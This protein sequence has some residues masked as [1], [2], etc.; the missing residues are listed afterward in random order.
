MRR[1]NPEG[2]ARLQRYRRRGLQRGIRRTPEMV[3]GLV[4]Y[5]YPLGTGLM[6]GA[7]FGRIAGRE[8]AKE[9][10]GGKGK[11][12]TVKKAAPKKAAAKKA[13]AKKAVVKKVVKK[14]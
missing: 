4:H 6:S 5:N 12:K 3:G 7:G 1:R 11:G 14:K 10:A 13:P 2:E 8:A 9:A